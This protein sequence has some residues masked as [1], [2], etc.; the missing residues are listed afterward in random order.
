LLYLC[1]SLE[2]LGGGRQSPYFVTKNEKMIEKSVVRQLVEE[3]IADS[4]RFIVDVKVSKD[5]AI[6]VEIDSNEGVMIDDCVALT[7][8]IESKLDRD[9]E[10]YELEVGSAG[11]SSPFKVLE[12]Y[13]KYEGSEVEVLDAEGKKHHGVLKDVTDSTFGL[14]VINKVKPEGAKRKVEVTET[15]TFEYDKIKYTKYTIRFK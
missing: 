3:F 2:E 10:D 14:E 7:H 15:L 1:T 9:V 4:D 8:F 13:R 12:Q 5:N 6:T 11:L